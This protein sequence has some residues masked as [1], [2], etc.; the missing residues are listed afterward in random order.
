MLTRLRQSSGVEGSRAA[1]QRPARL[2]YYPAKSN[3]QSTR[4]RAYAEILGI[5]LLAFALRLIALGSREIW[6]DDAFSIFLA[7]Q[8]LTQIANGT[9]ADTM[10]PLYYALL[11]FWMR[12]GD[13]PF[14]L[15]FLSVM[16][17]M[18]IVALVYGVGHRVFSAR[19]ARNA[20][21]FTAI[22]PLQIYHAQ[23]LRMYALLALALL[24]FF[25]SAVSGIFPRGARA[26]GWNA[27]SLVLSTALALYSHNLA[28]VTLIVADIYLV[29]KRDWRALARLVAAQLAG[30]VLFLPWLLYVPGQLEKIQRAFWTLRPGV[31]DLLQMLVAFTT[32]LP[33]PALVLPIA[34]FAALAI[35]ILASIETVRAF[36]R[37][38]PATLELVVAFV[39]VPPILLFILSYVIRPVFVPRGVIF[40]SLAYYLGLGWLAACLRPRALVSVVLVVS[41]VIAVALAYQ[42]AY[43]EFPRSPY[44]SADRFLQSNL[45]DGDAIVHDN[46]LSFFPMR[47]YALALAQAFIADPPDSGSDTLAR[48]SMDALQLYPSLIGDATAGAARVWF[49]IYQRALDEAAAENRVSENKAWLDARFKQVALTQF[50]DLNVYLYQK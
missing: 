26:N 43:N 40:S 29:A 1:A 50:N 39:V 4:H 23:E 19:A 46:K 6:Y 9:A 27:L 17:S 33:L 44:R 22:A 25:S 31:V 42:Y 47:Y 2:G 38:A 5:L 30:L 28:I 32:N 41:A 34:L 48:G 18:L 16:L 10:P 21:L 13:D 37:G 11:H 35:F 45:R 24:W 49:V 8:D 36:R 14:T 15:R 20:A 3:W 12:L 7:R